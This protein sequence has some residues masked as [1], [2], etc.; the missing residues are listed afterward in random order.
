MYHHVDMELRW[1][2]SGLATVIIFAC[3][4]PQCSEDTDG[5]LGLGQ[6]LRLDVGNALLD[7]ITLAEPPSFLQQH[8]RPIRYMYG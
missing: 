8:S 5:L 3:T 7:F 4:I 1:I 6:F 2:S